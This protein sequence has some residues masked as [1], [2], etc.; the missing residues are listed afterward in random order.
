MP[1]AVFRYNIAMLWV[2]GKK[3]L[4]TIGSFLLPTGIEVSEKLTKVKTGLDSL[5]LLAGNYL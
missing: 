4:F 2:L 3:Q 5:Y 1:L